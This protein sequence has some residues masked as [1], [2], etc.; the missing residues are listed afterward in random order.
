MT[1]T[2]NVSSLDRI[3]RL[4]VG[5]AFVA[6]PFVLGSTGALMQWILP[7]IGLVLIF[8]SLFRFCPL[9]RL[10]GVNTCKVD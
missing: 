8:T 2:E 3:V 10:F 6:A 7:L 4:I 5:A 1:K 9:Y